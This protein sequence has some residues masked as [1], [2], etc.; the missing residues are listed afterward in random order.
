MLQLQSAI[1]IT[2]CESKFAQRAAGGCSP[3]EANPGRG[4]AVS[5][6]FSHLDFCYTGV[7]IFGVLT[8][9]GPVCF[10]RGHV[11][12]PTLNNTL[13]YSGLFEGVEI[14]IP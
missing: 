12:F 8:V 13:G 7:M 14:D 9:G 2:G 6:E 3:L 1:T 4:P 11:C 5:R 10:L